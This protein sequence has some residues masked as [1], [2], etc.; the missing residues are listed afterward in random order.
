MRRT[1]PLRL[2][3]KGNLALSCRL[4]STATISTDAP[5]QLRMITLYWRSTAA[6]HDHLLLALRRSYA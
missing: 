5:P 4:L 6:T 2:L 1:A 3:T